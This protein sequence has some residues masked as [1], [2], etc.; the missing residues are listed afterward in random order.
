MNENWEDEW[1]GF[2]GL[3]A[4]GRIFWFNAKRALRSA[5]RFSGLPPGSRI[6][7]AGCGSGKSLRFFRD[8][9]FSDVI[10]IDVSQS[11][12][13]LCEKRGFVGGKDV[14]LMDATRTS[15]PDRNFD[16]VFAEGVL[17]HFQDFTPFV[18][19]MCRLSKKYVMLIQPNHFSLFG[20]LL[21]VRGEYVKE[22]PYKIKDF[23]S[24][25]RPFGFVLVYSRSVNF[26]EDWALLFEKKD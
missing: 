12:L 20:K 5:L 25:F 23:E 1:K 26:G 17:E 15:F 7:D 16:L 14:F 8:A 9:G 4:F 18:K 24:A 13:A 19:E 2:K 11:G 22:F 6:L 10:G 21:R 3:N